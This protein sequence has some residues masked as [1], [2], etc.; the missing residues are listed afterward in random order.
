MKKIISL[1]CAWLAITV[2]AQTSNTV[3][4]DCPRTML[5]PISHCLIL[6][7]QGKDRLFRTRDSHVSLVKR[8]ERQPECHF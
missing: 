3:N 2:S 5:L 8:V 1:M 6:Q 4:K 7:P